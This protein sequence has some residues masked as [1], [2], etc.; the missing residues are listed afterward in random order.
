MHRG[1]NWLNY[2]KS[3]QI[4]AQ[5]TVNDTWNPHWAEV[6]LEFAEP[7]SGATGIYQARVEVCGSVMS[8]GNS[9]EKAIALKQ[10]RIV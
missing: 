10:Y 8:A 7:D 6:R 5:D 9:G 2:H 4:L 1:W 3:G